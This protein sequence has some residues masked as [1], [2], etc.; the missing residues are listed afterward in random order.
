MSADEDTFQNYIPATLC[1][2]VSV[3]TLRDN[4]QEF[5]AFVIRSYGA[6]TPSLFAKWMPARTNRFVLMKFVP[7]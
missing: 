7:G 4:T 3:R 5:S 6:L 2:E 1:I